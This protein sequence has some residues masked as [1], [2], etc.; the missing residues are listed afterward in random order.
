MPS[1]DRWYGIRICRADVH[2]GIDGAAAA[3]KSSASTSSYSSWISQFIAAAPAEKN[4]RTSSTS[5]CRNRLGTVVCGCFVV[6]CE[7]GAAEEQQFCNNSIF[8][9][10]EFAQIYF[11]LVNVW[12]GSHGVIYA[13]K[14]CT[15][16]VPILTWSLG[17]T[18]CL[19]PSEWTLH[20]L[21]K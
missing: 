11:G 9:S 1:I 16:P 7:F 12:D 19:P 15:R 10:V 4:T 5:K 3:R 13:E 18:A 14:C 21:L 6:R 17:L 8:G 20:L 2:I